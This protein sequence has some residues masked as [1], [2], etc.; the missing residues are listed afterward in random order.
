M[1]YGRSQSHRPVRNCTYTPVPFSVGL[2]VVA[3]AEEVEDV[4]EDIVVVVVV[5]VAAAADV[6]VVVEDVV[7]ED[8]VAVAVAVGVVRDGV[9]ELAPAPA[10]VVA[11][12]D[13]ELQSML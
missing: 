10:V 9:A 6:D 8:D 5:V 3:A 12:E 4:V 2:A 11:T 7:V 1:K 13:E